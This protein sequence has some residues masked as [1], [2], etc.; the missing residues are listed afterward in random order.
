MFMARVHVFFLSDLRV[1]TKPSKVKNLCFESM[2]FHPAH[3][4]QGTVPLGQSVCGPSKILDPHQGTLLPC[5]SVDSAAISS[6][7]LMSL[8]PS[9][10]FI[11]V[12]STLSSSSSSSSSSSLETFF[13]GIVVNRHLFWFTLLHFQNL[14]YLNFLTGRKIGILK[15]KYTVLMATPSLSSGPQGEQVQIF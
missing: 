5:M 9:S 11:S 3:I 7:S 1:I 6:S 13:N 2:C 15:T 14:K 12:S 4:A 8:S 10:T